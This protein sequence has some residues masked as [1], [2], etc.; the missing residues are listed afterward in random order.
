MEKRTIKGYL[1]NLKTH[2]FSRLTPSLNVVTIAILVLV[3]SVL[4][5][6]GISQL[7]VDNTATNTEISDL[8]SGSGLDITNFTVTSGVSSALC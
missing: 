6:E 2:I 3:M 1:V 7:T 8:I 5:T 4:S